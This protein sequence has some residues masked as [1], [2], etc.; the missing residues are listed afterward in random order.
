MNKERQRGFFRPDEEQQVETATSWHLLN[1]E[2]SAQSQIKSTAFN[3]DPRQPAHDVIDECEEPIELT[4]EQV[5]QIKHDA[6]QDGLMQG[7]EAGFKQGY[8]KGKQEGYTAGYEEGVSAGYTDGLAKS[9]KFIQQQVAHFMQLVDKFSIPLNMMDQQLE[10]QLIDMVLM[11]VK[12]VVHVE[13]QINPQVILDTVKCCV[14]S[15]PVTGYDI[16]IKLHPDD[17]DI[18]T[19]TYQPQELELRQWRLIAEPALNRGDVEIAAHDSSVNY[20]LDE[21]IRSV[22]HEFCLANR[23]QINNYYPADHYQNMINQ[24]LSSHQPVHQVKNEQDLAF[25]DE[26]L[27]AT[28][29]STSAE[30]AC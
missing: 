17:Y 20:R 6:Y 29:Q 5:E 28:S 23:Y 16:S 25:T 14:E 1:E 12:E 13:V 24:Q 21:R 10:K 11:L 3:Y 27:F 18:I 22:I 8:E 19:N 4:E 9:D 2:L 15:L 7:K 26:D 30:V